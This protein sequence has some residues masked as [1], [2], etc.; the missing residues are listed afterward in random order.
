MFVV[1]NNSASRGIRGG[2]DTTFHARGPLQLEKKHTQYFTI[3]ARTH[4]YIGTSIS[5]M[6]ADEKNA[7]TSEQA[8]EREKVQCAT[9]VYIKSVWVANSF[10]ICS[11]YLFIFNYSCNKLG[12]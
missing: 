3:Y 7:Q 4:A 9:D 10:S 1:D 6:I 8:R 11:F 2:I 12:C 5:Q